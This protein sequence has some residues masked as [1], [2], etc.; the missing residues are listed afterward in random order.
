MEPSTARPA[1]YPVGCEADVELSDGR[2][3]HLRPVVPQDQ[4]QLASAI[5]R[6]DV[7]T[8]R[9]RFLGGAPPRSDQALQRL[10]TVDYVRRFALAAFDESGTGVGIARYEGERTWPAVDVAVA[11]D[12]AWRGV[13]LGRELAAR[14]VQR[15]AAQGAER[16]TADFYDDNQ[17][18][19]GLL[20]EAQLLEHRTHAHG[21]VAD[22]VQ[23]DD[24]ALARWG[25]PGA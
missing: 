9:R 14:V 18:V 7:D 10:V 3:V 12:P 24:Q 13:G 21:V 16:L 5:A 23:L 22:E 19:L 8:L 2:R 17:Q 1:G 6:A 15:A 4:A 20:A 25:R 11:V